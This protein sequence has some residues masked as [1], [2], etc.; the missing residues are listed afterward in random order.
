MGLF[1]GLLDPP[2]TYAEFFVCILGTCALLYVFFLCNM[3]GAGDIKLM[4]VCMGSLGL[5]D[6]L[7]MIFLGLL[8]ALFCYGGRYLRK[9][10]FWGQELRMAPYLF[11]GYCV[12]L[13]WQQICGA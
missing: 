6:G 10:I 3:L 7:T 9:G 13:V 2:G 5:K 12:N 8:L 1:L 4:A 11:A